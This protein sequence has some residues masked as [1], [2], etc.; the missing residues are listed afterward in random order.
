MEQF[1]ILLGKENPLLKSVTERGFTVPSEIQLKSIPEILKGRDVIAGASTGS[2]KTLAF[3]AGLIKNTKKDFGVQTLV[4]TPTRELA[5]QISTELLD[6]SRHKDLDVVA[7]YGGVPINP[8]MRRLS[9]ADIVVG[10]PGRILDHIQRNS[11]DLSRVNT[12]VLDEADRML[13]MG[14]RDDVEMIISYC[15]GKRQTLLFSATISQDIA[16]L[17]KHHM[18]DPLEISAEPH[19]D[20]SKLEQV[21]YDVGDNLKYSLLMHLIE[22]EKSKLVMIFCN[23]RRNVDFV[24]NNLKFMGVDAL[25]IHGGFSQEKRTRIL[26]NFNSNKAHVLVCTDVA[27][28][29]L[30]IKG[31]SHVYN[32]DIPPSKEEYIHRIGR[33]ARAGK[34]GKVI[35]I[36]ASRDYDNFSNLRQGDFNIVLEETP[37]VQRVRIRWMPERKDERFARRRS[38]DHHGVRNHRNSHDNS[39]R[40]GDSRSRDSGNRD[41]DRR[42]DNRGRRDN[43]NRG[44]GRSGGDRRD[45]GRSSGGFSRGRND[46][47]GSRGGDGRRSFGGRDN[48]RSRDGGRSRSSGSRD[49]RGSSGG[50]RSFGGRDNRRSNS[51][52]RSS[53]RR[54]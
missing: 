17:A 28:R 41:N 1:E 47:R 11:I 7:I 27:A 52:N 35:N 36:L 10:T 2:G 39:R 5:E 15:P 53:G 26:E 8:Q 4:L 46:D 33:T 19:V 54:Y 22:N 25:P 51:N 3:A 49:S 37:Y 6:F 21:Y 43:D 48:S 23:T 14:F 40:F 13:D 50:N 30:D 29:G 32:Y 24:A 31:V 18:K 38:M 44:Q 45:S 20:P 12:L 42:D 16:L 9:D 34:E